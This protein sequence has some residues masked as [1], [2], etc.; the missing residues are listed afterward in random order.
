MKRVLVIA[1]L[2][3]ITVV[4]LGWWYHRHQLLT[5]RRTAAAQ[6]AA[7][8][9]ALQER[10]D[11]ADF[12]GDERPWG[13]VL[14]ILK[15][16]CDVPLVV[17]E[18]EAAAMGADRQTRVIV[19]EGVFPLD[20]LLDEI[21]GRM[22]L[23]WR[24]AGSRIEITA[25]SIAKTARNKL[26][27]RVYP[28]PAGS[29]D[30]E[31]LTDDARALCEFIHN[32]IEP[33]SWEEVGG[34]G[35]IE[36]AGGAMVV[37]QREGVHRQIRQLLAQMESLP[38][39]LSRQLD[40]GATA[41][42]ERNRIATALGKTGSVSFDNVP[43]EAALETLA[44]RFGVRIRWSPKTWA[45]CSAN[46]AAHVSLSLSN[47]SLR[48]ILRELLAS[49]RLT[50]L[51]LDGWVVVMHDVEAESRFH[52]VFYD[53]H[54]LVS[55]SGGSDFD[56]LIDLLTTTVEPDSWDEVGGPGTISEVGDRWLVVAQTEEIQ[57]RLARTLARLRAHLM[58]GVD[59]AADA[60]LEP[61]DDV[62]TS[63]RQ[64]LDKKVTLKYAALT[65]GE[66][67]RDLSRRLEI[68]VVLRLLPDSVVALDAP[69]TVDLPPLPLRDALALLL[70]EQDYTFDPR[71]EV[72]YVTTREDV[73]E[74][75]VTRII[76]VRHLLGSASGGFD[77]DTIIDL[78]TTCVEPEMWDEVGGPGST[79]IFRGLLVF[80]QTYD[81]SRQVQE[82]ID[83]LSEHCLPVNCGQ[84]APAT[85]S[86]RMP[87]WVGLS[88]REQ[89][90]IERLE[91]PVT[92][93]VDR[94]LVRKAIQELCS[95]A[96]VPV[97]FDQPWFE[98]AGLEN[99]RFA[100]DLSMDKQPL[101]EVLTKIERHNTAAFVISQ[102]MLLVTDPDTEPSHTLL[103]LYP[104][105]LLKG[106]DMPQHAYQVADMFT[107]RLEPDAWD[108][109]GG[110][111]IIEPVGDEWLLVVQ[112][113]PMHRKVEE[114]LAKLARGEVLPRPMP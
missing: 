86:G 78:V 13:E 20:E 18:I 102:G 15:S 54:D 4:A 111:G 87:V 99:G 75:L 81:V 72:L 8:E 19:P 55:T 79:E 25:L 90:L 3:G 95:Q 101:S 43:L 67:C 64:A 16:R 48:T 96:A 31:R 92:Y 77:E 89:R 83:A 21:T 63:V 45:I 44:A 71:G 50:Y 100:I 52:H 98:D 68:P 97:R 12:A 7:V 28:L 1:L 49:Q 62:S 53:V 2:A 94:P 6:A 37:R 74:H 38:R 61:I 5:D 112:T 105:P 11:T 65:L 60:L 59:P 85:D 32:Q 76:D 69:V 42:K 91:S 41:A 35:V 56:Q 29:A 36:S 23:S 22:D 114:A 93:H 103:R 30:G 107:E 109:N 108:D 26:I 113:L 14:D 27:T 9:T 80:R 66:V 40:V 46:P 82:L 47:V 10:I 24:R 84:D 33:D 51:I 104:L 70:E 88:D 58:P 34:D 73:E 39:G 110:Y 57:V 106:D 17:N